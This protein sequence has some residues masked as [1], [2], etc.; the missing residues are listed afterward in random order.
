MKRRTFVIATKARLRDALA[1]ELDVA[2]SQAAALIERGS[3]YVQ[4]KRAVEQGALLAQGTTVSVVLSEAG[5]TPEL[6]KVNAF[7]LDILEEHADWLAV[8]KPAGWV[9]QPTQGKRGDSL[10]DAVSDYLKKPAGLVHRLDKETSGVMVF[11]KTRE[12]T[13]ELAEAFREG[14]ARKRY[15]AVASGPL[16]EHGD[17]SLKLSKDPSRLGRWRA[18]A[19]ANGMEA[20]TRFERLHAAADFSLVALYPLTGR[21]HQLRAHLRALDAPIWGDAFY[22]GPTDASMRGLPAA[23]RCLLHAQSLR[24]LGTQ[25]DAPLPADMRAWFERAQVAAPQGDW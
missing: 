9:S 22:E 16:P 1:A 25:I 23:S 14:T 10:L 5:Q 15:V 18:S 12:G 24:V 17:I 3:V 8:N 20:K 19:K 7:S 4:G 11:G 6:A 21:T 13:R 2:A